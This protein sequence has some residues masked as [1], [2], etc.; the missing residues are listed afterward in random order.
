MR[1]QVLERASRDN[2]WNV[3]FLVGDRDR[4]VAEALATAFRGVDGVEVVCGNL[5]DASTDAIVC[6]GNSFGDMGGG[7]D[8]AVD[9][10]HE[11]RAQRAVQKR[12][13]DAWFGEV[14]VGSAFVMPIDRATRCHHLIFAPTMRVPGPAPNLAA[15]L[16]TRAALVALAQWRAEHPATIRSVA[17]AGM[18]TGVG[19]LE[20]SRAALQMRTAFE[21][22]VGERWRDAV[23]PALAPFAMERW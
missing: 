5:L 2:S 17:L 10:F 3:R 19:G 1:L 7:F 18:G 11:G 20:P 12:I 16:A 21:S 23:H 8:K 4:N 14:P 13:A 15:Y 6:P 22:I 9:D